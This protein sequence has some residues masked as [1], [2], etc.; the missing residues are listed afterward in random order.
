MCSV[1]E[2]SWQVV[3]KKIQ[4]QKSQCQGMTIEAGTSDSFNMLL[5]VT[6]WVRL[7]H[8]VVM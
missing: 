5:W 6:E 7:R 4:D 8:K 1:E 3:L 2:K